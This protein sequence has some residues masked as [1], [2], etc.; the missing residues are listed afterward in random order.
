M[1]LASLTP[2]R[3]RNE[4]DPP[5]TTGG[6]SVY[7]V[8]LRKYWTVSTQKPRSEYAVLHIVSSYFGLSLLTSSLSVFEY[9]EL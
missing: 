4:L 2:K 5:D 9:L 7:T 1:Y 6:I 3:G 8:P